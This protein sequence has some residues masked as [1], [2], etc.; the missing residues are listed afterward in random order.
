MII[1]PCK[2]CDEGTS[3]IGT[4]LCDNCWEVIHRLRGMPVGQVI[5]ILTESGHAVLPSKPHKPSRIQ[6]LGRAQFG[7][8]PN[9]IILLDPVENERLEAEVMRLQEKVTDYEREIERLNELLDDV[10]SQVG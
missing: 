4:G 3:R 5:R 8:V 2:I 10:A 6:D 9:A 1:S 7:Y